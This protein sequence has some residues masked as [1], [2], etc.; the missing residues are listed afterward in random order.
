[1]ELKNVVNICN[2]WLDGTPHG[3]VFAFF[4]GGDLSS[5]SPSVSFSWHSCE[6][7]EVC[8]SRTSKMGAF[9]GD[10]S[11]SVSGDSLYGSVVWMPAAMDG[12]SPDSAQLKRMSP[13]LYPLA[14]LRENSKF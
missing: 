3:A 2:C 7:C 4:E 13:V 11:V 6:A 8:E 14:A 9:G 10:S 5:D 12:I 1:M